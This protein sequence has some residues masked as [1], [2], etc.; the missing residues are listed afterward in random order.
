MHDYGDMD[1]EVYPGDI[2]EL[3]GTDVTS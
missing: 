3:S 1:P 2:F